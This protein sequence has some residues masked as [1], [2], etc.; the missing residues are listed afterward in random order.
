[1]EFTISVD[2]T[3]SLLF[4]FLCGGASLIEDSFDWAKL[5]RSD[6]VSGNMLTHLSVITWSGSL[7]VHLAGILDYRLIGRQ[8]DA[9]SDAELELTRGLAAGGIIDLSHQIQYL[10]LKGKHILYIDQGVLDSF[11]FFLLLHLHY[12]WPQLCWFFPLLMWKLPGV[13]PPK[14]NTH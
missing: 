4:L 1:M 8:E 13:K 10:Y 14:I 6:S 3:S 9:P 12:I 2:L 7:S 11:G 5:G